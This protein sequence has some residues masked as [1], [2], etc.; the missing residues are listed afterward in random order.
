V[1][2][3][4][5]GM[6]CMS[7]ERFTLD[8]NIL[9]YS[10]DGR[11]GSK[12]Q[13]AL[14][15]IELAVLADCWLTLQSLSEFYSAVTRKALMPP[16]RA[17][18]TA[19]IWLDL[20]PVAT[21][22]EASVRTALTAASAGRASYWDALLVATAAEAG[23]TAVLTED[24]ADGSTLNGVAVLNPFGDGDLAPAALCLLTGE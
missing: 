22:S 7:G 17:A 14:R 1:P 9:V 20:F 15:I 21:A 4:W 3:R 12:Q 11:S 6:R 24:M 10:V 23:C 8:T 16:E 5:T 13:V 2:V 18:E 19:R